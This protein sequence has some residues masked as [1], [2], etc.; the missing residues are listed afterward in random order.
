MIFLPQTL[1]VLYE[2]IIPT[3]HAGQNM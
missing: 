1:P 2:Q 3:L